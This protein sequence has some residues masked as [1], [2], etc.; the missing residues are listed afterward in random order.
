VVRCWCRL[1]K[2][3]LCYSQK[4]SQI[5]GC[6]RMERFNIS[7]SWRP[8]ASTTSGEQDLHTNHGC[9]GAPVFHCQCPTTVAKGVPRVEPR[10]PPRW[11]SLR[12]LAQPPCLSVH[13][14]INDHFKGC[15]QSKNFSIR[16]SLCLDDLTDGLLPR[17]ALS[18]PR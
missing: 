17:F 1:L 4:Y 18:A 16:R 14:K 15:F 3:G 12:V 11:Q 5:D 10:P 13:L 9:L 2:A 6:N 8:D 7:L